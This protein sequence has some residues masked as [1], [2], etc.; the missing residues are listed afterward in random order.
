MA[1]SC[2]QTSVRPPAQCLP[3]APTHARPAPAQEGSL[4]F[5]PLWHAGSCRT[6]EEQT[7]CALSNLQPSCCVDVPGRAG[8]RA[9]VPRLPVACPAPSAGAPSPTPAAPT[10][11][12]ATPTTCQCQQQEQGSALADPT[13][14]SATAPAISR[15][16]TNCYQ[17]KRSTGSCRRSNAASAAA[18]IASRQQ[19]QS[20]PKRY[21]RSQPAVAPTKPTVARLMQDAARR[22]Q[23]RRHLQQP[24]VRMLRC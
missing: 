23:Q 12:A 16:T 19:V 11:N 22:R 8:S 1:A 10:A 9:R 6:N 5:T 20:L 17:A 13:A 7:S 3:H 18:L 24:P 21:R 4:R 14:E 2:Q 15:P